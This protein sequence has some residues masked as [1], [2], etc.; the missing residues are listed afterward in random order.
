MAL[1]FGTLLAGGVDLALVRPAAAQTA[2]QAQRLDLR[3]TVQLDV[4]TRSVAVT[5]GFSG[6]E[7][8]VFGAVDNS[9]QPSPESGYYDV[10]I[11]VEGTPTPAVAR[12][13]S[14]VA[15]IWINTS[16]IT[17]E[18]VPSYY[19]II[20]TRPLDE[21]ADPLVLRENDIGFEYVRM[22]PVSGWQTGLTTGD[23]EDFKSSVVRLKQREHLYVEQ[24]V[25]VSFIG[26]SLFRAAIN[27]P[28]NVPVGELVARAHLLREGR[29]L[30]TFRA[31]V[32]LRREGVERLLYSFA[33]SLPLVYGLVTVMLSIGAGLAATEL[34][35]RA[36]NR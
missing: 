25:G 10:V 11:V 12:K 30:H 28:A 16:S 17:F 32:R 24:P 4:S 23:L 20:S 13:K 21:V 8:I 2:A 36:T 3:E 19:A 33:F 1:V 34:F 26:R 31:R 14:R 5:S 29:L 9:R 7:I 35:K 6:T 22:K 27:L 15:G 18:S